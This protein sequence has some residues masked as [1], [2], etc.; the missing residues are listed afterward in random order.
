VKR[1]WRMLMGPTL[2]KCCCR[3]STKISKKNLHYYTC[4]RIFT[5]PNLR[6]VIMTPFSAVSFGAPRSENVF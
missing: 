6:N 1:N 3:T 2:R 4:I 5:Y